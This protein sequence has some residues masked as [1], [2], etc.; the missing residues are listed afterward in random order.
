MK[1]GYNSIMEI[2]LAA[3]SILTLSFAVAYYI[4]QKQLSMIKQAA[5]KLVLEAESVSAK[6]IDLDRENFIKF[7][8]DSREWAFE[9]IEQVQDGLNKFI[10]EVEPQLEY[11]K[12]YGIVV[13][14]MIPPHDFALKKISKELEE[15]KKLVPQD[16]PNGR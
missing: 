5:M 8:S 1:I 13:D 14:G 7:L 12:Q 6:D 4:S 16:E 11:Y 3:M 9:Y 10:Q 15:L 2:A